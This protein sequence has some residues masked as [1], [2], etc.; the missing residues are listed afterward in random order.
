[1]TETLF[2]QRTPGRTVTRPLATTEPVPLTVQ[3]TVRANL[4]QLP[5]PSSPTVKPRRKPLMPTFLPAPLIRL[6]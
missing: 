5:L 3:E 4:R 1:M 6:T 2:A